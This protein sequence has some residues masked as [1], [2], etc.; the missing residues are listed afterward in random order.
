MP[1]SGRQR[2]PPAPPARS[3]STRRWP[4][5]ARPRACNA[6]VAQAAV[7]RG[8]RDRAPSMP[9]FA[10]GGAPARCRATA[11]VARRH[12]LHGRVAPAAL[13]GQLRIAAAAGRDTAQRHRARPASGPA[14]AAPVDVGAGRAQGSAAAASR[15]IL[16]SARACSPGACSVSAAA[17]R[18]AP[19]AAARATR[20]KRGVGGAHLKLR[21]RQQ[22][23]A[24][25]RPLRAGCAQFERRSAAGIRRPRPSRAHLGAALRLQV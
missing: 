20:C 7:D 4:C 9:R 6:R 3:N 16:P 14:S 22:A 17:A 15:A 19:A 5:S 12:G 11:A 13:P 8:D 25:Q 23:V 24:A 18:A 21:Q 10:A 2:A 1:H